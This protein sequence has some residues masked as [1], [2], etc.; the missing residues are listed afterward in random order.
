MGKSLEDLIKLKDK[1]NLKILL[2]IGGYTYSPNIVSPAS[3]ADGRAKFATSGL[4]LVQKYDFD[5]LDIDWEYWLCSGDINAIKQ[6]SRNLTVLLEKCRQV[7]GDKYLLT[8]ASPA[9][10][11][12]YSTLEF[13]KI[14]QY[15]DFYNIMAYD[16]AGNWPPNVAAHQA[17]LYHSKDNPESTPLATNDTVEG[18]L[19]AGSECSGGDPVQYNN[20][21]DDLNPKMDAIAVATWDDNGQRVISY[22]TPDVVRDKAEYVKKNTLG[23]GM[24]WDSAQNSNNS[25]IEAFAGAIKDL[26]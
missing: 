9:G 2:S 12:A 7:L 4:D 26:D 23:G 13:S 3:T 21:P 19:D 25:L 16:Y 20:L 15:L 14:T 22:D 18:Y 17:N 8:F 10:Q 1:Y 5:G 6:M 11:W 24:F